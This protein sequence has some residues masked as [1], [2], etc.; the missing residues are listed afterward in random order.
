MYQ[1]AQINIAQ[2]KGKDYTDPIMKDFVDN[3]DR[4]NLLAENSP[5]YVWRLKDEQNNAL[6]FRPFPEASLLINVSVWKDIESLKRYVYDSMHKEIMKRKREWFHHFKGFYYAL[7]W[8]RS[9]E[10]PT[11]QEASEKLTHLQVHGPT[12]EAFTFSAVFPPP[13]TP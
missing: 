12:A 7:W 1:L 13:S 8:I 9:G 3:L 10:F 11:A 5:G 2:M 4:I 6:D